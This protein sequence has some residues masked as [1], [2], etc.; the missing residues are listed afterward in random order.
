LTLGANPTQW[1]VRRDDVQ[2]TTQCG[3]QADSLGYRM[4]GCLGPVC[5]DDYGFIHVRSLPAR[6]HQRAWSH[7]AAWDV[8]PRE[9]TMRR[10]ARSSLR[11]FSSW[12]A[13]WLTELSELSELLGCKTVR[14]EVTPS[15]QS[16][17]GNGTVAIDFG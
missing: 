5:A 4:P 15:R 2:A 13:W 9:N 17:L 3:G 1:L 8:L 6:S 12:Y 14:S 10:A 7:L 11:S 16:P